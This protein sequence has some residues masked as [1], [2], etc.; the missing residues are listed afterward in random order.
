MRCKILFVV[1]LAALL[2]TFACGGGDDYGDAV[3]VNT[4]FVD[5]MQG[6]ISDIDKADSASAVVTAIDTY[7]QEI[8]KLAPEMKA[9]AAMHPEWKDMDKVPE[10][11]KP[12]QEK[13]R[14]IAAQ[15]PASLMKTMKYMMDTEVQEAHQ[16]LQEAMAKMQ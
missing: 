5:A 14:K 13:V 8:E 12:L 11:L 2:S 1:A 10:E 9:I 15:I 3:K 6:Y 16:R 4:K 7:A